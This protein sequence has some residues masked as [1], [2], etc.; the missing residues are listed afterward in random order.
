MSAWMPPGTNNWT[1]SPECVCLVSPSGVDAPCDGT[2][3]S[4]RRLRWFASLFVCFFFFVPVPAA[5]REAREGGCIVVAAHAHARHVAVLPGVHGQGI[6]Q[7]RRPQ[8]CLSRRT[9]GP[10]G[11]VRARVPVLPT[12]LASP[13]E[14]DRGHV[15]LLHAQVGDP[16]ADRHERTGAHGGDSH[17]ALSEHGPGA[18]PSGC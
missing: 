3:E 12:L 4:P 17:T 13:G 5:H 6:D 9:D 15:D 8:G 1:R 11:P 10:D 16:A 14:N 18:D 2:W 7:R